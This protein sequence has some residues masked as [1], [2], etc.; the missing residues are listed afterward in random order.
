MQNINEEQWIMIRNAPN[1]DVSNHGRVRNG[2]RS[3][4][5]TPFRQNRGYL[6]IRITDRDGK[7]WRQ[8]VHRLVAEAFL[9]PSVLEVNHKD[10]DKENNIPSNL[11]YVTRGQN[12][13]H[14]AAMGAWDTGT[15]TRSA[16]KL[17]EVTVALIR[18]M[19]ASDGYGYG[20]LAK[21]FS[22]DKSN[23]AAIVRR[24]SWKNV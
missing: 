22:V 24:R 12:Q 4:V 19:H 3:R 17:D 16:A 2:K 6:Q 11:E 21:M 14:A 23:I 20:K 10:M 8:T 7:A 15:H 5:L 13:R 18:S 9:G 1:Y